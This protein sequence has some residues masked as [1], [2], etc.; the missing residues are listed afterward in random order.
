M[1]ECIKCKKEIPAE[2][3]FC[4][5]CG[6]KQAQTK[7]AASKRGN[8]LGSAYRRG[9]TWTAVAT[10]GYTV[11]EMPD[12]K[13]KKHAVRRTKGGFSSKSAALE[14]CS[15]LKKGT[16][17]YTKAPKFIRVFEQWL[18]LFEAKGK[19]KSV[20]AGYKS[21]NKHFKDIHWFDFDMIGLDD[22]QDC[23]TE[24]PTGKR[25]KELMRQLARHLYSFALP[26]H[27]SDMNYADFL[28]VGEAGGGTY[29]PFTKAQVETIRNSLADIPHADIIYCLIY[30]GFRPTELLMLT[31]EDFHKS[32]DGIEYLVSGI[33]TEAGKGRAVTISPKIREIVLERV[34]NGNSLLFP[35][36]DGSAMSAEYFRKNYFFQALEEMGIQKVPGKDE[37]DYL[38]PYSCRHTFSN[39]LKDAVGSDKDKAALIGHE[40]YE[41]TKK[42]YQ[43]SD[44]EHIKAITD[45]F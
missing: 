37:K 31:K 33:K 43:S 11:E 38:V 4:P 5:W 40:D 8:G 20:V 45:Q 15:S 27:W 2:A 42:L 12:G 7:R 35:K 23:I 36:D 18:P 22:L 17:K 44:L 13:K 34:K 14:F 30:T 28:E 29:K 1:A 39:L 26:R 10:L 19:S 9:K 41:T 25:M 3:L 21:A 32:E 6:K 16:K 24:C